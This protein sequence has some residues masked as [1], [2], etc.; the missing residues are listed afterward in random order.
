MVYVLFYA[1]LQVFRVVFFLNLHCITSIQVNDLSKK[2][3][4]I[5]II[6]PPILLLQ[7]IC[8]LVINMHHQKIAVFMSIIDNYVCKY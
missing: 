3:I 1:W 4:V 6:F 7:H 8:Y 5:E 2:G